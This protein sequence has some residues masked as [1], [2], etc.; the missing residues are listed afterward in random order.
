MQQYHILAE[1]PPGSGSFAETGEIVETSAD[2]ACFRCIE[3]AQ[4]GN[5]YG[6]W[7]YESVN[8]RHISPP[9]AQPDLT[10]EAPVNVDVPFLSQSANVL[11]CTMGNWTG[12]PTSYLYRWSIGGINP[13]TQEPNYVCQPSDVGKTAT[14]V[15]TAVNE[16]G[17][18]AA[19][20]SNSVVIA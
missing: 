16:Q 7:V 20:A 5:R 9:S 10:V 14:C 6:F 3:L 2:D 1:T 19:P 12:T 13:G 18:V 4:D 17:Q 11:S 8:A 15:V